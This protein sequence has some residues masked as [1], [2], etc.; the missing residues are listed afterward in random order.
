M[1]IWFLSAYDQPNGRSS[2]T[3]DFAKTLTEFGHQVTFFT[4]S[5][6]HWTH[7]DFLS[8]DEK[9]RF[10]KVDGIDIVWL[11]T[12][13]Y[14]GNGLGRG[15]NMISNAYRIMTVAPLMQEKPDVI[16]APSVPL[17][18]GWAG[19]KLAKKF[20]CAFVF[21]IRDLWPRS[22]VTNGGLSKRSPIYHLFRLIEKHLYRRADLIS[23]VLP[24]VHEH[25]EKSGGNPDHIWVIP[26]GVN[27]S[28]RERS[29]AIKSADN[30]ILNATYVGGFGTPHDVESIVLAA[31]ILQ[32][33]GGAHYSFHIYG[34]G[35][36]KKGCEQLAKSL[37]LGNMTF[38]G[39]IPKKEIPAAL[40]DSDITFATATDT[41]T[42]LFGMNA[43]KIYDYFASSKPVIFA[44]KTRND[45]VKEADAGYSLS[46][47]RP[48]EIARALTAFA[49]L[50][51]IE[52]VKMGNRGRRYV[53]D[54]YDIVVLAK[55][56]ERMLSLAVEKHR[57]KLS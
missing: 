4:N 52:R 55:K 23:T 12:R 40:A 11:K 50:D 6:C 32:D 47:E 38:Y 13:P 37:G 22:L 14:Q 51:E 49:S 18:T 53:C 41:D 17:G 45:P 35:P 34:D 39:S 33:T 57:Y 3:Y 46:P 56:M 15:L 29:S 48:E 42:N 21:E 1:K 28:E 10:E 16:L 8:R 31:Q 30:K 54:N 2:R 9:Y 25:V 19:A 43:N 5:Y 20:A 27:T 26:N 24:F 7:T 36:K 44:G